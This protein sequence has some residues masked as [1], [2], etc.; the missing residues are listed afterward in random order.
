MSLIVLGQI[1]AL[2]ATVAL[3]LWLCRRAGL[4]GRKPLPFAG[5]PW[6]PCLTGQQQ[7]RF[8]TL[9][10]RDLIR[11]KWVFTIRDGCVLRETTTDRPEQLQL[12]KLAERCAR[13]PDDRW[14]DLIT[15][16]FDAVSDTHSLDR[17]LE[18]LLGDFQHVKHMLSVRMYPGSS[19][20]CDEANALVQRF[21]LPG[22]VSHLVFE[23]PH[24]VRTVRQQEAEVWGKTRDELFQFALDNLKDDGKPACEIVDLH[25]GVACYAFNGDSFFTAS[26]A[27]LLDYLPECEGTYGSIVAIPTRH[28]LV[29]YPIEDLNV[30]KAINVM[31]PVVKSMY[32]QGPG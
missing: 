24:S 27:L 18:P 16:Y 13:V 14:P 1:A 8:L 21:D 9:V 31:R 5:K 30:V 12:L 23:L 10:K 25:D 20:D 28:S 2:L 29:C 11:R 17:Q 4:L 26:H 22:I 7:Q 6:A 3:A 15:G 19:A 32:E